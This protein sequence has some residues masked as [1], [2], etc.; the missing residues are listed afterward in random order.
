LFQNEDGENGL[1]GAGSLG[2]G[3]SLP[4]ERWGRWRVRFEPPQRA[5]RGR[6]EALAPS[7]EAAWAAFAEVLA[8]P[9]SGPAPPM[10][11]PATHSSIVIAAAA[12]IPRH[13]SRSLII[14]S[15]H[16]KVIGQRA[17]TH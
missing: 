5:R 4:T 2:T 16:R 13:F 12:I 15:P 14:A 10:T 9:G 1:A 17:L 7:P 8:V 3:A 6:D 11:S